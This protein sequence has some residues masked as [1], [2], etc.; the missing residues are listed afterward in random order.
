MDSVVRAT[1]HAMKLKNKDILCQGLELIKKMLNRQPTNV[2]LITSSSLLKAM[3]SLLCRCL[4]HSQISIVCSAGGA[5]QELLRKDHLKNP[6][7]FNAL[8]QPLRAI[9]D[10]WKDIGSLSNLTKTSRSSTASLTSE[11]NKNKRY[12]ENK[13]CLAVGLSVMERAFRLSILC[14]RDPTASASIF[15][16]PHSQLTDDEEMI[17]VE[18]FIE[19]LLKMLDTICIPHVMVNYKHLDDAEVCRCFFSILCHVYDIS[20]VID[21][22]SFSSKLASSSFIQLSLSVKNQFCSQQA[23][24][25]VKERVDSFLLNLCHNLLPDN[26]KSCLA[27][28]ESVIGDINC[29]VYDICA[30]LRGQSSMYFLPSSV[31]PLDLQSTCLTLMYLAAI[32]GDP[33]ANDIDVFEGLNLYLSSEHCLISDLDQSSLKKFMYL[34]T[35]GFNSATLGQHSII[36]EKAPASLIRVLEKMDYSV[37]FNENP[38]LIQWAYMT[39]DVPQN[40][41]RGFLVQWLINLPTIPDDNGTEEEESHT[42]SSKDGDKLNRITDSNALKMFRKGMAR[43]DSISRSKLIEDILDVILNEDEAVTN[44]CLLFIKSIIY[45]SMAA[46]PVSDAT[47]SNKINPISDSSFANNSSSD[48]RF[49]NMIDFDSDISCPNNINSADTIYPNNNTLNSDMIHLL[50]ERLPQIVIEMFLQDRV[51]ADTETKISSLLKLLTEINL[52]SQDST[53]AVELKLVYYVTNML[54]KS[55]NSINTKSVIVNYLHCLLFAT[56][57]NQDTSV[58]SILLSNKTLLQLFENLLQEESEALKCS[59]LSLLSS[60]LELQHQH[61]QKACLKIEVDIKW[62]SDLVSTNKLSFQRYTALNFWTTIFK[63][64]FSPDNFIRLREGD[65]QHELLQDK[66]MNLHIKTDHLRLLIIHLQNIIMMD[67]GSESLLAIKCYTSLLNY[68]RSKD[69]EQGDILL[70]QPWN[71]A[72]VRLLLQVQSPLFIS[73]TLIQL[74]NMF[75]SYKFWIEHLLNGF[76]SLITAFKAWSQISTNAYHMILHIINKIYDYLSHD[77]KQRLESTIDKSKEQ[78]DQMRNNDIKPKLIDFNSIIL[79]SNCSII[80]VGSLKSTLFLVTKKLSR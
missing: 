58:L 19:F 8:E 74:Y 65:R 26:D 51:H 27:K 31:P 6:V 1:N 57:N 17:D 14:Q 61:R 56:V 63:T 2:S 41:R 18:Q 24:C 22:K 60:L 46:D 38:L 76:V 23:N 11:E 21:I 73:P 75:M 48:T 29:P 7:D 32:Y 13:Q 39:Q 16:A 33:L 25:D 47:C 78:I 54:T 69:N 40:I 15:K 9:M 80:P 37:I 20:T 28:M 68:V 64:N 12:D 71:G 5:L 44:R 52:K 55:I 34:Y 62:L 79:L 50:Q 45:P 30:I 70:R 43:L 4:R 77:Q 36:K 53:S 42:E 3:S 66:D 72:L 35:T 67:S 10:T 49:S 59:I